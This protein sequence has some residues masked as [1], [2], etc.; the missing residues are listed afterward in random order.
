MKFALTI[1][2]AATRRFPWREAP[3]Y[4]GAPTGGGL[5]HPPGSSQPLEGLEWSTG[6]SVER[7]GI[8]PPREEVR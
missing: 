8:R 2:L 4:V 3:M 6:R 5:I 7:G 1:T